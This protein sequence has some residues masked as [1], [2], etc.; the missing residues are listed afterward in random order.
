MIVTR[1]KGLANRMK[2]MRLWNTKDAYIDLGHQSQREYN[3]VALY[4]YNMTDMS[5][6]I[7]SIQ[8]KEHGNFK[9]VEIVADYYKAE[10]FNIKAPMRQKKDDVHGTYLIFFCQR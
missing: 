4:K 5:A 3:V 1:N 9:N 7:G 6:A 2:T 8:L 10:G